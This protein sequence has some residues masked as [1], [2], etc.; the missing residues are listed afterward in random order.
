MKP[1]ALDSRSVN[2]SW[3]IPEYQ[4]GQ[5]RP[6]VAAVALDDACR[7]CPAKLHCDKPLDRKRGSTC[8][9]DRITGKH[10]N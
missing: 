6:L 1:T 8:K 3:T 2:S 5:L 9:R 7:A 4:H 10:K